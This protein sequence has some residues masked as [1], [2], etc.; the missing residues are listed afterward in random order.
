MD[1]KRKKKEKRIQL[2]GGLIG[3]C[4]AVV[5]LFYFFHTEKAEAE[6]R[7]VEI[8]NY[9]K[10]QCSTYTH[11]NESSESKSL[12]RA[13]ESARQM[14]TNIDMEIEN[15]GHLSQE[16]LK[17]NLQTLWVDG[18]LVLDAVGKTD[19]EYSMDESLTGEITAYLQKDIIM[20]FAGYEERSYSER[21]TREDGSY[22]DIAA[23]ARKDAPGIVAIY[24]YTPPEFARNYTLTI[25]GLLNGYSIQKDGTVIVADDGIVVASND[26]SLL[27]QNTADNEVVQAMK[28]HTDSQHIY[29]LRKEGT[30]CYGIMLK[31]R[32]YYI[33]AYL[34]DTEVFRNLPLSV[35]AVVFLYLLIFGI[36]CFWGYRA[37]LAHRKQEQ[38][39][40]EKYKAELL[41]A[42]KKAEAAN[43]AKTEFLQRMSHDIR[44]PING[45]CGMI[46]VADHYAEDMK[47]QTECRAKIKEASHLLLE[48]INEVLDMSKLESDEVILEEIPFNL[49]SI[50]EEILG[51]IEQMA[52]E[53]N[54]RIL[55]EEKEVTHWNLIGSPVHVKRI[56]MN[57]LSN[58]VKYN[59]ENG[60]V[61]ISCREIPSEQTAMT[62]LEFVCRD[63]GIGMTE[64]FQKR[65]FEPFAQEHA[66]SRTKF[67]GTGLGMPITK[68]LVEKM[69]G[70][71]SFESKEGIG[72]TFLIRIPFR[73]DTD[74]K[75]RTEAEEKTETSI[76]GL[77]VL[78]TED[79]EL[80][81]EI[82]EFVL[83]NE[84]TVVTKAW[85]GQEAVDIFRKSSPGE[86]D[87]ILMDIMMPV[88]NGYEAA[89]MIR[90]LDRE[91]AKVIPIIAMTANAFIEDRMR[92][93]EAGMDEHIAKPVDGKLL[94]K[95]I[96]ELVKHNQREQ[97]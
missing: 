80:N 16:F 11:Y 76:Q 38:E 23:C 54:I 53:Q 68:K 39:K 46:D 5:S 28:K 21:F 55:W 97:L 1:I 33:Y 78:L 25:Q 3:I 84:G 74:R 6:K 60:Y 44:T 49:N 7:M 52:T 32:D 77:H 42:A 91:D 73:I 15:G 71:I 62:T 89:K 87:V 40:D 57:I 50:S 27:G 82:A 58:A 45:I 8:V 43:E 22:I 86:F 65:I 90:S 88:M 20:D 31:Q 41:R 37:D 19:C 56:L 81:M 59:K 85:N 79:N 9:V 92:A 69:G 48:L 95:V 36:F 67:A 96:N 29:H 47:K 4:V 83:Q 18:I 26:E 70:T 13:I 93:K 2:F 14:S 61:Y 63:T 75:D 64:A 10:V 94:V 66:G 35:T 51:V 30:G 17:E 34:P 12:L 72:T 24:Y